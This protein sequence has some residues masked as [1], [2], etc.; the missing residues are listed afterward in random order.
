MRKASAP[1]VIRHSVPDSF[2]GFIE[3]MNRKRARF[4]CPTHGLQ[5]VIRC[6]SIKQLETKESYNCILECECPKVVELAVHRSEAGRKKLSEAKEQER[7]FK[8]RQSLLDQMND[9]RLL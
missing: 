2:R 5:S 9:A 7:K 8:E 6:T 4:Y 1:G 3:S